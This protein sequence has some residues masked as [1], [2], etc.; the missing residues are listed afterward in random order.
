MTSDR[1]IGYQKVNEARNIGERSS[2]GHFVPNASGD[3]LVVVVD[4]R[5]SIEEL[6]GWLSSVEETQNGLRSG[7]EKIDGLSNGPI[8]TGTGSKRPTVR[9]LFVG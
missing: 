8:D 1:T 4:G 2:S 3:G 5:T 7:V 6:S 9:T